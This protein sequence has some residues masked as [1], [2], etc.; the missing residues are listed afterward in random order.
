MM[1]LVFIDIE[2]I[3][4]YNIYVIYLTRDIKK[5]QIKIIKKRK[6]SIEVL[7]KLEKKNIIGKNFNNN[8]LI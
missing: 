4:D 1:N 5:Y 2:K 7:Q 8:Q 6:E 3:L